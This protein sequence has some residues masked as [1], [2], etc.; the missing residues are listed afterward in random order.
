[1]R[2]IDISKC[3]KNIPVKIYDA[4]DELIVETDDDLVFN[5]VRAEIKEKQ[6]SGCYIIFQGEKIRVDRNGTPEC[7]PDGFFE[8]L[9][10]QLC[11]LL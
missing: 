7:Y 8:Y 10:D 3:P 1:M 2:A 4:N 9:T 5:W 6:L 11:R